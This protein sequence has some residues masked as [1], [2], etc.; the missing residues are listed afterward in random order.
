MVVATADTGEADDVV[1]YWTI[2]HYA[3]LCYTML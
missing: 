2:L 3:I 1:L